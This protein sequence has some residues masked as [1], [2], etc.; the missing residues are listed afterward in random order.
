M[1]TILYYNDR[2]APGDAFDMIRIDSRSN[3]LPGRHGHHYPEIFWLCEGPCLHLL[4]GVESILEPGQG[5]FLRALRDYHRFKTAGTHH[6]AF[7]NFVFRPA[8]FEQLQSLHP[9]VFNQCFPAEDG[10]PVSFRMSRSQMEDWN[11]KALHLLSR[12]N[13]RFTTEVFLF[14]LI[15]TFIL[16]PQARFLRQDLPEWL[17][18]ACIAIQEPDQF[19]Q[20]VR[21]FIRLAGRGPEHVSRWTR[22]YLG[23]TPIQ[24]VNEARMQFARKQLLMTTSSIEDI[25]HECGFADAS[26]FYALFKERFHESPARFRHQRLNNTASRES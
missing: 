1:E 15:Q 11:N 4:N 23:K 14:D 21:G 13:N 2:P 3:R 20:G 6:F 7:M 8:H 26:Q 10:A 25:I 17:A 19:S 5:Y 9:E 12:E 16:K 22:K 18:R 24:L